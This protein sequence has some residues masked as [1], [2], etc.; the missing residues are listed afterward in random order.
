MISV[1]GATVWQ[2][3]SKPVGLSQ[4]TAADPEIVRN[5]L[6]DVVEGEGEIKA[7][8]DSF[9]KFFSSMLLLWDDRSGECQVQTLDTLPVNKATST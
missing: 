7:L 1:S 8:K 9:F 2:L 5:A 3:Q 4:E 6:P